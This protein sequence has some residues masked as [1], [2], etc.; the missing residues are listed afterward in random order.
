MTWALFTQQQKSEL[1]ILRICLNETLYTLK[2][3]GRFDENRDHVP[4]RNERI[5]NC[6][7]CYLHIY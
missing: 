5:V 1:C 6:T 7:V 3:G 4:F 2:I